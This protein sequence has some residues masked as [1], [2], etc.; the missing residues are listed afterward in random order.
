MQ[1]INTPVDISAVDSYILNHIPEGAKAGIIVNAGDGRLSRSIKERLGINVIVYNIEPR[2][3]LFESLEGN[4]DQKSRNPWDI[5]WYKKIAR[6][7]KGGLDFICFIN[8]HEYWDG[9]LY[10]LQLILQCLKPEGF[11]FISFYN[12]NSMYEIRQAVPPFNSGYEQLANPMSRWAQGDLMSWMVYLLN[13]GMIIDQ[14]WG[15]LEEKAFT[16]CQ[17]PEKKKESWEIQGLKLQIE[18]QGEAFIYGAPVICVR[19][20]NFKQGDELSPQFFAVKYNASILQAILFPYLDVLPNELKLFKA[21]LEKDNRLESEKDE[22]VLLNFLVSQLKDFQDVKNVLVVGC[23]WG[24]DLL[25]LKKIKPDWTITGVDQSEDIAAIG[26]DTLA[27]A[28]I[29]ITHYSED[30]KLPFGN[31]TFDLVLSLKHF[32]V[33]YY[34]LGNL[35]AKE[36]LRVSKKGVVHFEDLRGPD[37]SMQ[38]KLYSIPDIYQHYGFKPEVRFLR[39]KEEDTP[40]YIIEIKKEG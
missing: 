7:H 34:S 32:S 21:H 8:I 40:L 16:Y 11:G 5:E 4:E 31:N 14:I 22:F 12:K 33:I 35:L 39:I 18:D 24:M 36:M 25:A 27:S 1:L 19:F 26:K 10:K 20:R 9:D 3:K 13:T 37:F 28:G 6:N 23:N 30:G 17:E 2:E 38:L 29:N 15:I